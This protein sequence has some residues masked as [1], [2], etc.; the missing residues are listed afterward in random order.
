[1]LADLDSKSLSCLEKQ[2]KL[3]FNNVLAEAE[4]KLLGIE[5]KIIF[6]LRIFW[7]IEAKLI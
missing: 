1:M 7:V 2:K 6:M 4:I 3:V 5:H